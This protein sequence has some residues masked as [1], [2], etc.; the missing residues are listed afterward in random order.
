MGNGRELDPP[1]E[2]G[3]HFLKA[4]VIVLIAVPL[5]FLTWLFWRRSKV[6]AD[7]E[8]PDDRP[9]AGVV[10]ADE[11]DAAILEQLPER[12]P[13]DEFLDERDK[14]S[15]NDI[16]ARPEIEQ[17]EVLQTNARPQSQI[18]EST[19]SSEVVAAETISSGA[20]D[21]TEELPQT[22]S[23]AVSQPLTIEISPRHEQP[24][25]KIGVA[26]I[27]GEYSAEEPVAAAAVATTTLG[28]V[29]ERESALPETP[30]P[31]ALQSPGDRFTAVNAGTEQA[32][33]PEQ[34][35]PVDRDLEKTPPQ[36][37]RPPPQKPPRPA[38]PR[39][40]NQESQRTSPS[41]VSLDIRIHITFDRFGFC[42]V[43]LLPER[44]SGLDDEVA[45]RLGR[46]PLLLMAQEDWYA[47][48]QLENIGGLLRQGVELKGILTDGRSARWL[49]TGRDLYVLASHQRASGFVS[50]NRLSLGRSHV[51]LC[52]A[53]SLHI[54]EAILNEAGC[55]GYTRL[56]E[57]HGVPPGWAGL[58]GVTPTKA[59]AL[60]LGSDP[61]Y[62]I[63][64]A[65][66]IEIDLE[67]GVCLR[68]SV[69]LAGYPPRIK[70]LG[71]S[72]G[73]V[74][75]LIDGKEAQSTAEGFVIVDGYD[76]A[77]HHSVYCE[78]LSCSCSYSIE[79]P[80]D[81][82]KE[83]PAHHFPQADICGPL[84][85]LTPETVHGR[86]FS[87]PMSNPLLLGAEPG[88]IFHCSPRSVALWKG[89]VPFDVVWALPAQP[90]QCNKT[91]ARILQFA[92]APVALPKPGRKPALLWS[93]AILDASRKGLLIEN[94]SQESTARWSDYKKTAR[95]IWR[96]SR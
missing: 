41:E 5:G 15:A 46:V 34:A 74:R 29:L 83:W 18:A 70:L 80:P 58:R 36:R 2:E 47:D 56:N 20:I 71:E 59:M 30:V 89:F 51:V 64:P 6:D 52:G 90:L 33:V 82:W 16:E 38:A 9:A 37:Y 88:Q 35:E 85:Q 61:F 4:L 78:G 65:P 22:T 28:D 26:G 45:V 68:N 3:Q 66:D 32:Q 40:V 12:P 75:V 31:E 43:A 57:S 60:D 19:F 55:E 73:T 69:W 17:P 96:A 93:N 27:S 1:Y 84:V 39:P 54:V 94:G 91:T 79:E 21:P 7:N 13:N 87:G 23:A 92:H 44:T 8:R 67:G 14:E 53:D 76:A 50:T 25:E 24:T 11:I 10:V 77:G 49:L 95:N 86:L 72:T 62:A 63:K 42:A 48:L 81:S